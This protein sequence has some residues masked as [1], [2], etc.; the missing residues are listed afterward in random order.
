MDDNANELPV[1]LEEFAQLS[2]YAGF[3]YFKT[4]ADALGADTRRYQAECI[5]VKGRVFG[6]EESL[7][8]GDYAEL[9]FWYRGHARA[10]LIFVE[11]L[12][13]VMRRLICHAEERDEIQ[14]T[15]GESH[16]IHETEYFVQGRKIKD[17]YKPNRLLDNFTLSFQLFPQVFGSPFTVDYGD[18]G[19]EQFQR[20]VELRN[21]LTHPKSARDTL[22]KSE[23]INTSSGA[24]A[25]FF[26]C[27]QG[28]L[29]STDVA[30]MERSER[31]TKAMPKLAELIRKLT[32]T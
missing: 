14:L 28:I 2:R 31:E 16:L 21:E 8:Q 1:H 24:G 26:Q 7:S 25:W 17:R 22:L 10:L 6:T 5:K 13:F 18:H 4:M 12:L 3:L 9:G 30:L 32:G 20:L 11:G 19:W 15:R 27:I 29:K 23:L